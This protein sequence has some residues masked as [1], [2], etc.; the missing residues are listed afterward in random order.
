MGKLARL[1]QLKEMMAKER[2]DIVGLQETIKQS[3]SNKELE[4]LAPGG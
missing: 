3:F 1:R 2:P 4:A